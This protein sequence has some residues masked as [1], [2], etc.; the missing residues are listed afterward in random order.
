MFHITT[1][2]KAT[3]LSHTQANITFAYVNLTLTLGPG[4]DV[5]LLPASGASKSFHQR[6]ANQSSCFQG[7]A[8]GCAKSV[9]TLN[10]RP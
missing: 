3:R 4:A 9:P 2:S 1:Y 6:I 5:L 10:C 7:W 8:A